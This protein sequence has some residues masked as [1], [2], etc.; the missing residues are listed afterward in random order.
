VKFT[1]GYV[2]LK[3]SFLLL[4]LCYSFCAYINVDTEIDEYVI[5]PIF[6]IGDKLYFSKKVK[7]AS[8]YFFSQGEGG[9][10][11]NQHLHIKSHRTKELLMTRKY[12]SLQIYVRSSK[13][14]LI[15]STLT[16]QNQRSQQSKKQFF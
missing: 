1:Y 4:Y 2:V 16:L 10:L 8:K 3:V 15:V 13:L 9:L 14:K 11:C 6:E 7:E 5:P 12:M